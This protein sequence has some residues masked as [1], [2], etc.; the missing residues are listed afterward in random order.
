VHTHD[1]DIGSR[2][3]GRAGV[4]EHALDRRHVGV[5]D[6]DGPGPA[7]RFGDPVQAEPPG[8]VRHAH[9]VDVHDMGCL[10]LRLGPMGT[11]MAH[12]V[13]VKRVQGADEPVEARVQGVVGRCGAGVVA[14]IGERVD[15]LGLDIK[16][17]VAGE[18]PVGI[19]TDASRWQIARSAARQSERRQ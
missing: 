12:A 5:E 4:G 9:A 10:A 17:G 11:G 6:V 19:A 7:G 18:W 13:R 3:A 2:A 14:S 15:D 8:Y 1:D 16:R